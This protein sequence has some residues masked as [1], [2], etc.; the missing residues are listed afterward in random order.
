M[1]KCFAM[2]PIEAVLHLEF[3][4][5]DGRSGEGVDKFNLLKRERKERAEETRESEVTDGRRKRDGFKIARFCPKTRFATVRRNSKGCQAAGWRIH[6]RYQ[7]P[8]PSLR[9]ATLREEGRGS[10]RCSLQ[11]WKKESRR[12]HET[13][14][15]IKLSK[16]LRREVGAVT[17]NC[18]SFQLF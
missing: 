10:K 2:L 6:S 18:S 7:C 5:V 9:P 3:S 11:L 16:K 13:G 12:S 15:V 4:V 17:S 1:P 8:S 14:T